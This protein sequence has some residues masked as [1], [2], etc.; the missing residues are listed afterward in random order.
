MATEIDPIIDNWYMHLDKGQRFQVVDIDEDAGTVELQHFDGDLEE[1]TMDEW[2]E[3]DIDVAE[4]PENWSGPLDIGTK[5]DF[6]TEI[7]DT[8]IS[9][10]TEPLQEVKVSGEREERGESE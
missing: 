6:G 10:W 3:M 8:D 7:T 2:Y 4:E 1:V 9:E 5:D